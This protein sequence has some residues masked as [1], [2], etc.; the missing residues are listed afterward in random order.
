MI[1]AEGGDALIGGM[2]RDL[3]DGGVGG[4]TLDGGAGKDRLDAGAGQDL[5]TGGLAADKFRFEAGD[6]WADAATADRITDF[7]QA[8]QDRVDLRDFDALPGTPATDP[9]TFVGTAAFSGAAGELRYDI[10]GGDTLVSGDTNGDKV[11]D[12]A[13]VLTGA[14]TLTAADFVFAPIASPLA[15]TH[16]FRMPLELHAGPHLY[17]A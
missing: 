8:E 13:I 2:G 12:F 11:A 16:V 3:L 9:F 1:G 10:S 14:I 6:T 17:L 4:D 5:L 7:S 15:E